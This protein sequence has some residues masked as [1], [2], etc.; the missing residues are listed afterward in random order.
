M[1]AM[2]SVRSV[3][4]SRAPPDPARHL[5]VPFISEVVGSRSG[6]IHAARP[7]ERR[8]SFRFGASPRRDS[9]NRL[10]WPDVAITRGRRAAGVQTCRIRAGQ[11]DVGNLYISGVFGQASKQDIHIN[12]YVMCLACDLPYP[13]RGTSI[14][15]F[16]SQVMKTYKSFA[17]VSLA[18]ASLF[19]AQAFA[20]V[21]PAAPV[22][23]S[24]TQGS[25]T[26]IAKT[27]TDGGGKDLNS[28]VGPGGSMVQ[29]TG[30]DVYNGQYVP[31]SYWEIGATG[32]SVNTIMLEIA[33]NKN[34]NSF[35][36]Y[37]PTDKTN[38][39]QLFS[40][41]DSAG[42]TATLKYIGGGV[43]KA[44]PFGGSITSKTF[45]AGA[46][47]GYYL[48]TPYGSFYSDASMNG[49]GGATYPSGMP[50]MVAYQG[51]NG[52]KIGVNGVFG[53]F[54][55]NEVLLAWE[56]Q[57]FSGS[58]LDYNDFMVLVESVHS[59]PEPKILGMFG[60]GALLIGLFAGLRRRSWN[61]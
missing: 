15:I 58:D 54:L 44:A 56:D 28:L 52:T 37:D 38:T 42:D 18:A 57:P 32:G 31:S 23:G 4:P 27:S 41:P 21:C 24:A 7:C 50:H 25:P 45:G 48:D 16:R 13:W 20:T 39:L 40:G 26:C 11:G 3:L 2:G 36:I 6:S 17:L 14:C 46:L 22:G 60:L 53:D 34:I 5:P 51:G 47:F 12:H 1:R 33:G 19:T 10:E 8:N 29:G 9:G 49:A 55:N 35:G 61:A 59:V 30:I 43:F